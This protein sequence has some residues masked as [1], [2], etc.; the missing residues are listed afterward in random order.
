MNTYII[1]VETKRIEEYTIR[2]DSLEE[3][4]QI[5]IESDRGIPNTEDWEYD[6]HCIRFIPGNIKIA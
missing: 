4:K 5:A 3:A 6:V 1:S 2:A